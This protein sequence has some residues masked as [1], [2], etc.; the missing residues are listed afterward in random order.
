MSV[1]VIV[2]LT[3]KYARFTD[4]ALQSIRDQTERTTAVS[5]QA[6]RW[7]VARATNAGVRQCYSE[8]VMR[9][10]CDDF[11]HPMAVA[12]MRS[13][14]DTHPHTA[15][16]Y[17]DYWEVGEVGERVQVVDQ[18]SSPHPGCMMIRRDAYWAIDGFNED[19]HRQEGTDFYL[20][21]CKQHKVDHLTIPL[22]YYRRHGEQMSNAHN[23]VVKARH[24][25]KA[26]HA[27]N[28]EKILAVIPARGGSKGI[29]RKNLVEL[30]GLPLVVHAIR[31]A[32]SSKH[33]MLVAV[34][35]E[36]SEIERVAE[37]E[38]V[39]VIHRKPEDAAD[40][41]SLIT[42]AQHAMF[43]MDPDFRA[44][45][46]VT[47]QPTAPWT[48]V[49]ALD[50]ALDRLLGVYRQDKV[51]AIVSMSEVL[52]KHPFRMYSRF[53]ERRYTPFFPKTAEAYLQRQDREPAYQFTGG[54]YARRRH[55]LEQ[56]DGE[57]FALGEWEGELV[58][59]RA[60]VDIDS[61]FDLWLAEAIGQHWSEL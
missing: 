9:L 41:V 47:I 56:W 21:L 29:P 52:G 1:S 7:N 2:P 25:V 20:R 17:S 24:E 45:I 30:N 27:E 5:V 36:D 8:Y 38:G 28:A 34:S 31:M 50:N 60:G 4:Q 10:D 13:Y 44:N 40:D 51:D 11:L 54:F 26:L 18:P 39:T 19:L 59:A 49:E 23:E 58:P 61:P 57:G 22:W 55:L 42:V 16:V 43:D 6:D 32:K 53:D 3:S 37:S 48:P 35:T 46:V 15:A 33:D 12:V 14:L